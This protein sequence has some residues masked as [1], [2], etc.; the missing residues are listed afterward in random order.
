MVTGRLRDK[1]TPVSE[2]TADWASTADCFAIP[3]KCTLRKDRPA[4]KVTGHCEV[5][6]KVERSVGSSNLL[7]E[8]T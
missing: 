5:H 1:D 3:F 6:A 4:A 8:G 2:N 7:N